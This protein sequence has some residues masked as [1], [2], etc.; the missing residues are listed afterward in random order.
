MKKILALLVALFI[1]GCATQIQEDKKAL[2]QPP[3]LD[4]T[5][6]EVNETQEAELQENITVGETK[7]I[8]VI[9]KQWEFIP[10]PIKVNKG[11]IVILKITTPDVAHGFRLS[12]YGI[13]ERISPGEEV[14]VQFVADKEGEFEFFCN[15]PCGR[16]HG[17]MR[18]T[19]VVE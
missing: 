3:A 14:I 8:A 6:K 2:P 17:G 7:E 12:E 10:D 1:V 11:D 9:A 19:L 16:G 5:T 15:V 13:N 4:D 18:G